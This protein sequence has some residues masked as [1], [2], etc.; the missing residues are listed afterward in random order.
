MWQVCHCFMYQQRCCS[1]AAAQLVYPCYRCSEC[2]YEGKC[3][4]LCC[5]RNAWALHTQTLCEMQG[6]FDRAQ[7][8]TLGRC[9]VLGRRLRV[10]CLGAIFKWSAWAATLLLLGNDVLSLGNLAFQVCCPWPA[11]LHNLVRDFVAPP[12]SVAVKGAAFQRPLPSRYKN[13]GV[14]PCGCR[15]PSCLASECCCA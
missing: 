8:D 3:S 2:G 4:V 14:P 1:L 5:A 13:C 11:V 10:Q 15:G 6:G 7:H 9:A 12:P